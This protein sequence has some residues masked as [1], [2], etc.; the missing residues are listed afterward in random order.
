MPDHAHPACTGSWHPSGDL[1][2]CTGCGAEYPSTDETD[3]EAL[4]E[5]AA[6]YLTHLQR[7]RADVP[8]LRVIGL[9]TGGME[10]EDE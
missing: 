6:G 7:P 5:N 8:P 10:L 3:A 1:W 9:D 4:R 2:R